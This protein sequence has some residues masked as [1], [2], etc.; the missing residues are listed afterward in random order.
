MKRRARR[1]GLLG[2][3][4]KN[5]LRLG[6]RGWARVKFEG[7]ELRKGWRQVG[8][9]EKS[10]LP[11]DWLDRGEGAWLRVGGAVIGGQLNS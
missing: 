9:A 6:A 7:F 5:K 1:R 11:R 4:A 2:P 8:G 3:G 10:Y